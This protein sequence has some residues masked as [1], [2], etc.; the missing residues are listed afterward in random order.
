MTPST[1][2]SQLSADLQANLKKVS[3]L[4]LDVDGVLSDGTLF[5]SSSGEEVKGFSIL[6]GLGIKLLQQAG[7]EVA[8]ITGRNSP[9]TARRAADL[10]I[11]HLIQGR[12]DKKTALG[13]LCGLLNTSLETTAYM[14]DDLPDLGAIKAAGVGI[15]VPNGYWKVREQAD[16]CTRQEGGRGAVREV[17]DLILCAQDKLTETLQA[18]Q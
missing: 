14:G 12:E 4:A 5:F 18:F 16:I 13:D 17:A 10:G 2:L 7:I 11:R 6:D 9:L 3:L 8:L 15:T 1:Q